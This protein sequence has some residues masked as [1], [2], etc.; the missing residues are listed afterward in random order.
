[1]FGS[2]RSARGQL[3]MSS[4]ELAASA[5]KLIDVL[6]LGWDY[7]ATNKTVMVHGYACRGLSL[8]QD[9][10]RKMFYENAKKTFSSGN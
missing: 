7:Y 6:Q 1:M 8:P 10:L 4:K 5:R 3:T 9:V 2:D